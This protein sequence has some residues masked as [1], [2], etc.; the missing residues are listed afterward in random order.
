MT[1]RVLAPLAALFLAA[2]ATVAPPPHHEAPG[3][4]PID[5][6]SK[7]QV[8]N[9]E[10]GRRDKQAMNALY[11]LETEADENG[12]ATAEQ[13]LRAQ[14][15][16][17]Q[18]TRPGS[19]AAGL[20]P[21]QWE[22]L[23]PSNIGGRVRAIAFDPRTAG[24]MLAGTA[25][26]GVWESL[27]YGGAW[28]P[29]TDFMPNLSVTTLVFDPANSANVYLGTGE[30]SQ[31]LVGVGAFKSSDGGL[32]WR[33]LPATNVDANPDWRFVNR[34]AVH[35][36]QPQV[37]L[38]ALTNNNVVNG[39]IYR[40]SDGGES[41]TRVSTLKA[42]D[43]AFE[44]S[45]PSNAVAGLDDGA[46]AYSRNGG[47][48]WVRTAPLV[49]DPSGRAGTARI[50]IAFAA[51][52]P[53]TVYA[54]VDNAKGEVWRSADSGE[55]WE[56]LATPEHLAGQGDY[57]NAIW[58]DPTDANHV[59]VAGLDIYQ[60]RDGG[61]TFAKVSNWEIAPDSPHADHHA[62][63]SPPNYA[64]NPMVFNGNDGGIY[65][66]ANARTV[67]VDSGWTNVNNGLAVTQFYSGAGSTA[68]GGRIVGGTQDNGSLM[69]SGG[70]WRTVRGGDGGY[71]AVD[72][73]SDQTLY[74]SY[75]Y[76]A[77]H[78]S[79][80][81]GVGASYICQGITEALPPES[82]NTY[83]G[84]GATKK[85]NFIAP[86]ILDPN[87]PDR[88]LAGGASLWATEAAR[89]G[90]PA[91]RAIKPP[92]PSTDNFINAIEVQAGNAAHI[93][94]GHNNGE[95]YRTTNGTSATPSWTRV[96]AGTLPARRVMRIML[97]REN[98]AR[99][100]VAFTG[101]VD[102]NVWQ[103]LDGGASWSSITA[104]LPAAPVFD[105]KRHPSRGQWL[106]AATSV[107]VF[108]SENGG[109]SWSTTNEGPANI[110]VRELF[111]IDDHT[112]GAATYGRG[113]FK[114]AVAPGGASSYQDLWWAGSQENG[115]GMSIAQHGNTLFAAIYIYD[116]TGNPTWVTM[117][118]GSWDASFT[119]YSGAL[120]SPTGSFWGGYDA[121]RFSVGA[122]VGSASLRFDGLEHA[123]L[124]YTINGVSG[125]KSMSRTP[126]GPPDATP[127][128]SYGDLWWGG[129]QQN[130]WGITIA[131]QYRTLFLAWYTY[132]GAGRPIWFYVSGGQWIA[133]NVFR[134][135]AYRANG[136]PWLGAPYNAAAFAP[137]D[138][139]EVT[140]TF[141]D[142]SHGVMTYTI[143]GLTQ[144]KPISRFTF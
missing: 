26:G 80:T 67:T 19:K 76:L 40:S 126:F 7:F 122:P 2:C 95:V 9:R 6:A 58:V 72:P 131:Q 44:P 132:D 111:W 43:I 30:A 125:S 49:P 104:N 115:W 8:P 102:G 33:L 144:S 23:G 74:G 113:M 83:C 139:G 20:L 59:M 87:N 119:T 64:T 63:V 69:L 112:L 117:T 27:D 10:R 96:G 38:A 70:Q 140:L 17:R 25:S 120:Y 37:L 71:V 54:S 137:R 66:A 107:G 129:P 48:S 110:R 24:R 77:I 11:Q 60:S 79:V 138:V 136:S 128:A 52:R 46:V 22:P 28:R 109:Q 31:L 65:R 105:V 45:N 108:T 68:A 75:V 135:R 118:G 53:G 5:L 73:R 85:A 29:I 15:Q 94:V 124:T 1:A 123:T 81:G 32:T 61:T 133:S 3:A 93:W 13:L 47:S 89:I 134:G 141:T 14:A 55:T 101:F 116:A 12:A 82:G 35:P 130:G 21:F 84:A 78:R 90:A 98:P 103:T 99:A 127:M 4:A 56:K 114:V 41:W 88:M 16:R 51:S 86:F 121:T 143:D 142:L 100:I 50:E 62:L 57:D 92:T 36:S 18:A 42:L 39:A 97:D 91:W 106:Y 34:L